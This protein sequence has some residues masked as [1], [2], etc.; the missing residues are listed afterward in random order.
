LL[1]VDDEG[2]FFSS[3]IYTGEAIGV[4]IL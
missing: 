3:R 1:S 2:E 4:A